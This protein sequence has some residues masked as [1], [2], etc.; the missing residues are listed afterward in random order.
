MKSHGA[1]CVLWPNHNSLIAQR[2]RG[3]DNI[4]WWY[5][6][7]QHDYISTKKYMKQKNLKIKYVRSILFGHNLVWIGTKGN[8]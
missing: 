8:F 4:S 3:L 2:K 6:D 1:E 5:V 7:D